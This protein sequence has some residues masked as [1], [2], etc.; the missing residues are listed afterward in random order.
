MKNLI[1]FLCPNQMI[2]VSIYREKKSRIL[3][4]KKNYL[5]WNNWVQIIKKIKIQAVNQN[6]SSVTA[7]PFFSFSLRVYKCPTRPVGACTTCS[8]FKQLQRATCP[9]DPGFQH[10]EVIRL[11]FP[12]T[13]FQYPTPMVS[14]YWNSLSIGH[15]RWSK[16]GC[17]NITPLYF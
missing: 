7:I 17:T 15:W 11:L 4:K 5:H 13:H 9:C 16:I 14:I 3:V 1:F 12:P 6:L 8:Q 10:V 2:K